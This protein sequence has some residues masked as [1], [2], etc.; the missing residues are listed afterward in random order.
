MAQVLM[1]PGHI[2]DT[3]TK[4]LKPGIQDIC[5]L[6]L[7]NFLDGY[8][9]QSIC[10]PL[11]E[12]CLESPLPRVDATPGRPRAQVALVLVVPLCSFLPW[13]FMPHHACSLY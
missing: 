2:S 5:I 10:V 4:Y 12:L 7:E 9:L 11:G 6:D 8:H 13:S 3:G 1:S